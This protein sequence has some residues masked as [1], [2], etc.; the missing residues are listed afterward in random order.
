LLS[1]SSATEIVDSAH[2]SSDGNGGDSGQGDG[3]GGRGE[4]GNA[5]GQDVQKND[6]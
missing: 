6:L 5:K 2:G 4:E 3:Q 1:H